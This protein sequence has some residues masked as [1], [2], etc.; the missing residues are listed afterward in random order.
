MYVAGPL[1][2]LGETEVL[3][4]EAATLEAAG[5]ATFL[6]QRD[7]LELTGVVG[8]YE[9][10]GYSVVAAQAAA[11]ADIYAFDMHALWASDAIVGLVAGSEPDSGT[12]AELATAANALGIATVLYT[13]GEVRLFAAG[14]RLNP[15]LA[16][17]STLRAP[18]P[19]AP[20]RLSAP[21]LVDR[22]AA[23]PEAVRASLSYVRSRWRRTP[24]SE[25]SR[26]LREA[27]RR[28]ARLERDRTARKH[29]SATAETRRNGSALQSARSRQQ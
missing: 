29:I 26:P 16:E 10:R 20:D 1:F 17:L 12:V 25:L 28:G 3:T 5:F 15:I 18:V 14:T 4:Q 24:L 13:A 8:G 6:P 9:A 2:W 21:I 22:L 7:G 27:I 23:L 11:S 19:G